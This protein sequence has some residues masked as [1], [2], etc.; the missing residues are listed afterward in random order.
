MEDAVDRLLGQWRHERPDVDVSPMGVVGRISRASSLLD[1]SIG[2]T[3]AKHDVQVE[4]VAAGQHLAGERL[5][6][7]DR[8]HLVDV[9]RNRRLN[10]LVTKGLVDREPDPKDRRSVIVSLTPHGRAIVDR[11]LPDHVENERR[12]LEVLAPDERGELARLLQKLLV[13]LGDAREEPAEATLTFTATIPPYR[14]PSGP[15]SPSAD[16]ELPL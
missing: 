10:R 1:K 5:V 12:M 9:I 8:A 14:S 16:E 4:G 11:A 6:E 13:G 7:L 3:L 15:M 2:R